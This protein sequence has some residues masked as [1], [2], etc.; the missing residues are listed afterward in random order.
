[1]RRFSAERLDTEGHADDRHNPSSPRQT[2]RAAKPGSRGLPS[3]AG[4]C[5]RRAVLAGRHPDLAAEDHCQMALVG[6]PDFLRDHGERL[7]TPPH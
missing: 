7:T 1:M 2:A 6:E 4:S 3:L 5:Q